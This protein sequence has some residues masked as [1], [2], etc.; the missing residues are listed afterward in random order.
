MKSLKMA[1]SNA[2]R[3]PSRKRNRR[4]RSPEKVFDATD[5]CVKLIEAAQAKCH[6][7]ISGASALT[8]GLAGLVIT[9][10]TLF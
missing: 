2:T 3:K 6:K 10:I 7:D 5:K 9:A 8:F 1:V 4:K